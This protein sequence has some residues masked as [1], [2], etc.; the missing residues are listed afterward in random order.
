VTEIPA[1]WPLLI[2]IVPR[3]I[4]VLY[5]LFPENQQSLREISPGVSAMRRTRTPVFPIK[6]ALE[7]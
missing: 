6:M 7:V 3:F 4:G 5:G 1:E 2:V